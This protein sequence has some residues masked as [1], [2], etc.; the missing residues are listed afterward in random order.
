MCLN[1]SLNGTLSW[2]LFRAHKL[3]FLGV[4]YVIHGMAMGITIQVKPLHFQ[5]PQINSGKC[6]NL[7]VFWGGTAIMSILN[8]ED[9]SM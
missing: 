4:S 2:G 7:E 1:R 9:F 5:I 3:Y 6:H 8:S